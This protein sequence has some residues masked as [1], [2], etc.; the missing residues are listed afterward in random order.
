[1]KDAIHKSPPKQ[2]MRYRDKVAA[3]YNRTDYFK[4]RIKLMQWWANFLDSS[5]RIREPTVG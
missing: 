1:M 4:E 2:Y 3:A 5:A